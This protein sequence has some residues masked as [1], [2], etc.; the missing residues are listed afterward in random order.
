MQ[1]TR[2]RPCAA[3]FTLVELLVVVGVISILI[4]LLM[5]SLIRTYR[6]LFANVGYTVAH[7]ETF[8]GDKDGVQLQVLITLL[9]KG[10]R[11]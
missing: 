5:P 10:P 8:T 9:R 1:S 7:E 6:D 4:A 2:T 3:G 11:G